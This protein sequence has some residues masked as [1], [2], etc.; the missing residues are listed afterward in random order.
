MQLLSVIDIF[1]FEGLELLFV[2]G[3]A[4]LGGTFG[5]RLFRHLHI[6]QVVAYIVFGLLIGESGLRLLPGSA[7]NILD[8]LNYF[9]LG[10]IGFM[11]GGELKADTF[12]K[13][14]GQFIAILLAE[15]IGAFILVGIGVFSLSMLF[16]NDVRLSAALAVVL[17][18]ISSATDPA[19][20][21][22]VLW[23]YKTRG[24]LTTAT[25]AIVALDDALAL[26][27]YALGTALAGVLTGH[28]QHGIAKAVGLAVYELT[29]ALA[30]GLVAGIVLRRIL[31]KIREREN[32]LTFAV[33]MV[34][35][36]IGL[37]VLLKLDVILSSMML[38]LTLINA[39]PRRSQQ[40]FEVV[41]RFSPPIYVLFFVLAGARLKLVDM[42][43]W[44]WSLVIAYVLGRTV[45]KIIGSFFGARW[46]GAASTVRRYLGMCLFAQGG[47]A[48]GLSIV[49]SQRFDEDISSVVIL[50]V[51]ATTF[52]VQLLGPLF[53]K[54]GVKKAGE[55]GM[56]VTEEDLME[57]YRVRDVMETRPA[58]L[59]EGT[60]LKEVVRIV[61]NT[62]SY[63]Y[64][65]VDNDGNLT[66]CVT[67]D[68]L[69]NTFATQELNDWF[70]VLDI[71]EPVIADVTPDDRLSDAI[72]L[73]R[74]K[75]VDYLPVVSSPDDRH[76][77]GILGIR[78]V[79]RQLS[80]EVLARQQRA[81]STHVSQKA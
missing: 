9:A 71:V 43:F 46:S 35:L 69:R 33:G 62:S 11:I 67:F 52:I 3:V 42:S 53:I 45:G 76:L 75:Y 1:T 27:L 40:T 47:V 17:G 14:G 2:L 60:S 79:Q 29:L 6:P 13:Y 21:I 28:E 37:S 80:A 7:V 5:G 51:A 12:R 63:Y 61:G 73:A 49:A 23:E 81:D 66:G 77:I 65:V 48:I 4:I 50:V 44:V 39:A 72:E 78:S 64:V 20:T 19:S 59:Y 22:Q 68:G 26:A 55:I 18:A 30:V 57:T 36:V 16:T 38:G 58:L 31:V 70:V 54:S 34:L 15:G 24:A 32:E 56:N 74:R 8:P 10:I 41:K 25:I